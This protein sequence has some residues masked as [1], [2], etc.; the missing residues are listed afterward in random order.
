MILEMKEYLDII[1][2]DKFRIY[3]DKNEFIKDYVKF[4]VI[5]KRYKNNG[6]FDVKMYIY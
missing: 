6:V 5:N 2:D 1:I 4:L 3:D